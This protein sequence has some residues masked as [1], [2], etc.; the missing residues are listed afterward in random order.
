MTRVVYD[1]RL[2]G[3]PLSCKIQINIS[4]ALSQCS[5]NLL[6]LFRHTPSRTAILIADFATISRKKYFYKKRD[7]NVFSR[8]SH[9]N[10]KNVHSQIFPPFNVQEHLSFQAYHC[11]ES[12]TSN[13]DIFIIVSIKNCFLF[14]IH[15]N[16]PW[17]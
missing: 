11:S 9:G 10:T 16:L 5:R 15:F 2:W 1:L 12:E 3:V 4:R 17:L 8:T 6:Y 14:Q 7:K 13:E